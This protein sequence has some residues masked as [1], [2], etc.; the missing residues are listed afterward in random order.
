MAGTSH[1]TTHFLSTEER[2]ACQKQTRPAM[3]ALVDE[4]R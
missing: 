3:L 1:I 4:Q 2:F